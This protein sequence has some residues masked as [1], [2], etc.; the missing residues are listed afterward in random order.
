ME[1]TV[2]SCIIQ[3]SVHVQGGMVV[4]IMSTATTHKDI[5]N[6][7]QKCIFDFKTSWQKKGSVLVNIVTLALLEMKAKEMS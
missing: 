3:S 7:T 5:D 6:I 4:L 2:R 1:L